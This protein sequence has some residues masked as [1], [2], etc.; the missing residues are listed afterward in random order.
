MHPAIEPG[1]SVG[2]YFMADDQAPQK[3]GNGKLIAVFFASPIASA[4]TQILNSYLPQKLPDSAH[5]AIVAVV[6]LLFVWKVPHDV[7][8]RL[9]GNT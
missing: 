4:L 9:L 3:P 1:A 6:V 8:D 7:V 2:I 5:D